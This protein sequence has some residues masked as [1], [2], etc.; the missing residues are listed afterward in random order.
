M[1]PSYN[2]DDDEGDEGD[3]GSG[4]HEPNANARHLEILQALVEGKPH[5][6]AR[7]RTS[8]RARSGLE[9]F[10]MSDD[11]EERLISVIKEVAVG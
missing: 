5:W 8:T 9:G 11:Q 6:R 4:R 1:E 7:S 3:R 2:H 10:R